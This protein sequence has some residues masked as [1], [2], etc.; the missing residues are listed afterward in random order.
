MSKHSRASWPYFSLNFLLNLSAGLML[1]L[2]RQCDTV[3]VPTLS[4]RA[5][6]ASVRVSISTFSRINCSMRALSIFIVTLGGPLSLSLFEKSNHAG[7]NKLYQR[8]NQQFKTP[9]EELNIPR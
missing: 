6:C 4:K 5:I 8:M 2:L 3:E 7:I 9:H 1:N